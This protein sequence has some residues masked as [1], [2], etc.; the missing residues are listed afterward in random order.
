[1][2]I[3]IFSEDCVCELLAVV[4]DSISDQLKKHGVVVVKLDKGSDAGCSRWKQQLL[5]RVS[6]CV[7]VFC[8]PQQD[9]VTSGRLIKHTGKDKTNVQSFRLISA[10]LSASSAF[11]FRSRFDIT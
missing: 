10:H 7:F 3:I 6:V 4:D 11:Y 5:M 9:E 1:M 2:I 8:L